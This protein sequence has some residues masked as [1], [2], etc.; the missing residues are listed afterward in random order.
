[1]EKVYGVQLYHGIRWT[2]IKIH[3][4]DR[5]VAYEEGIRDDGIREQREHDAQIYHDNWIAEKARIDAQ[6]E[7][8]ARRQNEQNQR[9]TMENLTSLMWGE[10][11]RKRK[12]KSDY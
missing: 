6:A 4:H 2:A 7:L 3:E 10:N 8:E 12:K 9:D 1:M 11:P 5:R